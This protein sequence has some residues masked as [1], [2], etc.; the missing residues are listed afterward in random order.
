MSIFFTYNDT[1]Y[2]EGAN[3]IAPDN[4]SLKYGD[5]LFETLKVKSG[6][7]QLKEYHFERLF[8]GMRTLQFEILEYF[9]KAF[10][11]SKITEL[12]K[13]N[14]HT[15]FARVRLMVFRGNGGLYDA[16]N[17]F[18]NY[19]IQ[20]WSVESNEKL[21]ST[22]LILDVYSEAKKSCDR[23]ANI[24]NNNFLPYAMAA[25]HA[26][27]IKV[28]DCILLNIYDRICDT[29]I[30]NIFI[31]KDDII[32][33]PP[34]SEGCIAGVMRRFII[35]KIQQAEF[36]IVEKTISIEELENADEVFLTNAI[37]GI[38]WVRQFLDKTYSNEKIKEVYNFIQKQLL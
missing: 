36:K 22:G 1:I 38:R 3:V 14:N 4:R 28:D 6:V 8:S 12:C 18:P 24:K 2:P 26:T 10:L 15:S 23:F 27:K 13:K 25:L 20:T 32:Y 33:T 17:N 30:A 7:I 11:E 35:E 16:K 29:T 34:L 21:N 5:G 19:I 37:R 31:I 9:T